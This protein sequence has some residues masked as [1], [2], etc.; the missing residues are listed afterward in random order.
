ML[1]CPCHISLSHVSMFQTR[2]HVSVTLAYP[3]VLESPRSVAIIPKREHV[4]DMLACHRN[5]VFY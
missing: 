1:A 3:D 2:W 5:V 4:K